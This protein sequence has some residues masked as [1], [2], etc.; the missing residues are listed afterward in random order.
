MPGN[1]RYAHRI[2][3]QD[4]PQYPDGMFSAGRATKAT[5][6]LGSNDLSLLTAAAIGQAGFL[7]SHK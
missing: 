2:A 5:R 4:H 6:E 3:R 7:N 1:R